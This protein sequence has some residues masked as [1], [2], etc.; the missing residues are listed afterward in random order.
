MENTNRKENSGNIFKK[1]TDYVGRDVKSQ[2]ESKKLI[3]VIRLLLISVII[4]FTIN[5]ILCIPEWNL[6]VILFYCVFFVVFACLFAVSYNYR[7]IVTLWVFNVGMII[8]ICSIVHL[9]GWNIGVQHFIMVLLI[10]YFFSSYRQYTGKILYAVFLCVLRIMLFYIYHYSEPLIPLSTAKE[11]MLQIINTITIFLCMSIIAFIFSRDSQELES[12][13]VEYNAQLEKQ[14]NTDM[15]TGLYNRR[16]AVEYLESLTAK[17]KPQGKDYSG[18][19]LC[20][21]DIDFFKKVN[22]NYGH[23]AGDKVL[24]GIAEIF[25]EEM[26]E[27]TFAARWGGEEFLL[28]FPGC[29]GDNAYME[30]EKIRRK[31]KEMKVKTEK[32]DIGVTMTFGL[33]EYDFNSDLDLAIKEADKKLYI[34]KEQ[35][36]DR[37]IY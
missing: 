24:K 25:R 2:N 32:E 37:I 3:V 27:K 31:I 35:G 34:G 5:G 36:R 20:I 23:D 4:Y 16:K 22:D 13:L 10:L 7:S 19:S 17:K 9:L 21:C 8:W 15:L 28:L 33:T 11:N 29:N 18:F 1:A 12:K 14:A 30:L 6:T 26:K